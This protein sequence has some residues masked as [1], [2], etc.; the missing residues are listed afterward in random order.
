M[1]YRHEIKHLITP[2]DAVAIRRNM[3]AMAITCR[4]AGSNAHI[5]SY[6]PVYTISILFSGDILNLYHAILDL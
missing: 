2:A 5:G 1:Q 6:L 4:S 3:S